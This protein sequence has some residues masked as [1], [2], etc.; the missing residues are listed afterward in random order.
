MLCGEHFAGAP[1]AGDDFVADH[2]DAVL[3]A[4]LADGWPVLGMRYVNARRRG[5][6]LA[7]ERGDRRGAFVLYRKL[8]VP[9]ALKSAAAI[10][11]EA[12][13]AVAVNLRDVD[14]ARHQWAEVGAG[15][16]AA[17]AQRGAGQSCAV[18]GATA[19]EHLPPGRLTVVLVVVLRHLERGL[20]GLRAAA[21]E[22]DARVLVG[23]QRRH[24]GRQP[25]SRGAYRAARRI[26]DVLHLLVDGFGHLFAA[27]ADV[28]Q[29]HAR[30]GVE[31]APAL[32]VVHPHA[33]RGVRKLHT[34]IFRHVAGQ[35]AVRPKMCGR[36]LLEVFYNLAAQPVR[37]HFQHLLLWRAC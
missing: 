22:V 24:L 20:D 37:G 32:G 23:S 30:K 18:V 34:G 5:D 19:A 2:D 35:P 28:D 33:I 17:A 8:Q 29:P 13:A 10:R 14:V 3:V 1:E 7:D 21:D 31:P 9:G 27:V 16:E 12:Q 26:A 36:H 6:R 25:D 15:A 4:D 11:V